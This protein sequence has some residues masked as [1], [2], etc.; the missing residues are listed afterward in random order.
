MGVPP[1]LF[2]YCITEVKGGFR[3]MIPWKKRFVIELPVSW[4]KPRV[5]PNVIKLVTEAGEYDR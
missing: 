2:F 3:M 4:N 1:S 5:H